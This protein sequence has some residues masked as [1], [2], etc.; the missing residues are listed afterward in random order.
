VR[1]A[2]TGVAAEAPGG[3]HDVRGVPGQEHPPVAEARRVRRRGRPALHVVDLD[4]DV[5]TAERLA[6][7]LGRPGRIHG[8]ADGGVL[9]AVRVDGGEH[10]EEAGVAGD[11]E[12]ETSSVA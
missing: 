12:K 4:R 5:R 11:G 7:Q 8:L 9:G 6:D 10:R 3:R 1:V 2:D